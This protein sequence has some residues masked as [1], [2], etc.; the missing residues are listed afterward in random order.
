MQKIMLSCKQTT[1]FSSVKRFNKLKWVNRIQ[2]RLHLMMCPNCLE[3]DKQSQIIDQSM[4]DL[5]KNTQL[6]SEDILSPEK[7]SQIK[8]TVNQ[9]IK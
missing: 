9:Q 5:H 6:L 1:F 3:F 7:I 4:D 8:T 2:H